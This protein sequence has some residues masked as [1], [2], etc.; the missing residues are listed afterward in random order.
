MSQIYDADGLR[1]SYPDD[2]EATAEPDP[3]GQDDSPGATVT[4]P[5]GAFWTVT[6]YPPL[7]DVWGLAQGA[8]EALQEVYQ[9]L[10]IHE[11]PREQIGPF[12]AVGYD[13]NFFCL[14]LTSSAQIRCI[15][16]H[17]TTFAVFWQAE[18][19]DLG[20]CQ[21]AFQEMMH[22]LLSAESELPPEEDPQDFSADN[23]PDGGL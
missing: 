1:F 12:F 19:R 4:A 9:D 15:P 10:E 16:T 14:D 3:D 20:D 23:S 21:P 22:S 8:V 11:A 2:W 7:T 17:R 6:T 18:D 13:L 5:S